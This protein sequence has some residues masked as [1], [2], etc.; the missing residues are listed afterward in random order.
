M[1]EGGEQQRA[2]QPG[3]GARSAAAPLALNAASKSD[4]MLSPEQEG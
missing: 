2:L 3:A 4:S 1:G